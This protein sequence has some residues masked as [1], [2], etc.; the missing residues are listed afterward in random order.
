MEKLGFQLAGSI[1]GGFGKII[2]A[3]WQGDPLQNEEPSAK[4]RGNCFYTVSLGSDYIT[5]SIVLNRFTAPDGAAGVL[6]LALRISSKSMVVGANGAEANVA[7]VLDELFKV[8]VENYLEGDGSRYRYATN[9]SPQDF[10]LNPFST[11][12]GNFRSSPRWGKSVVMKGNPKS[13]QLYVQADSATAG[14]YL[15]QLP[16]CARVEPAGRV[17][18]GDFE[19]VVPVL[20]LSQAELDAKPT[21]QVK[22]AC[23]DGAISVKPDLTMPLVLDSDNFG[24]SP[25]AF[26]RVEFTLSR[27]KVFEA[28]LN[29]NVYLTPKGVSVSL[30][31][32]VGTV[33]VQFTPNPLVKVFN[34]RFENKLEGDTDKSL[35]PA[36]VFINQD[37]E[38]R[39]A[40]GILS[41]EGSNI[42]KFEKRATQPDFAELFRFEHDEP[43]YEIVS[44]TLSGDRIAI[45]LRPQVDKSLIEE[46]AAAP[47]PK[48]RKAAPAVV[49][50]PTVKLTLKLPLTYRKNLKNI[51]FT[52]LRTV[53]CK[54]YSIRY[55]DV[56]VRRIEDSYCAS[57]D[58]AQMRDA[59]PVVLV[60]TP[61]KYKIHARSVDASGVAEYVAEADK[62]SRRG[63]M[64]RFADLFRFK[65]SDGLSNAA[66]FGRGFLLF[67]SA[68]IFFVGGVVF[69]IAFSDRIFAYLG[70][71]L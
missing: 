26:E 41:F 1:D 23:A 48:A 59:E 13:Q 62:S 42:L 44:A 18:L 14:R 39:L 57:V 38:F 47:A 16:L 24:Y 34:I 31:P 19:P 64:S 11:V 67:L 50:R 51:S 53:R 36:L 22:V 46:D 32:S 63:A 20:V 56:P 45:R 37:K 9:L 17:N 40:K 28:L 7:A 10:K 3:N 30:K 21:I 27:Q 4:C 70:G 58:I 60:G 69:G 54:E 12:F 68:L 61:V 52:V 71:V 33:V 35:Y 66:Y 29:K 55:F 5:Y 6:K 65:D 43:R 2:E 25:D 8:L 49:P 15:R